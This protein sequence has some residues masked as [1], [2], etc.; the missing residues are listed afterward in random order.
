[1]GID[2]I[3]MVGTV[4]LVILS[5]MSGYLMLLRV[6]EHFKEKPDPKLT[7]ASLGE[8]DK[9][10]VMFLDCQKE[11]KRDLENCRRESRDEIDKLSVLYN[12]D[13]SSL[14]R[15]L[16]Q[17][18]ERIAKVRTIGEVFGQR[19]N[20]LSLKSDKLLEGRRNEN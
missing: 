16:E 7:Y 14:R 18:S 15:K 6:R 17:N 4:F 2:Q 9:L 11:G 13:L 20:E 8:L 3:Q 19:I 5:L 10:R 12:K 1:M